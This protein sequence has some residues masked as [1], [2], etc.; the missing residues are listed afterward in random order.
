MGGGGRRKRMVNVSF[1]S[2]DKRAMQKATRMAIKAY[3]LLHGNEL[4]KAAIR[5]VNKLSY[6]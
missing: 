2:V 3:F 4:V 1:R 5:G 6:S